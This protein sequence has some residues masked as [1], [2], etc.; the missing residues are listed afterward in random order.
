MADGYGTCCLCGQEKVRIIVHGKSD[1]LRRGCVIQVAKSL[2][3][4][5][6]SD[7]LS[8]REISGEDVVPGGGLSLIIKIPY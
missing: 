3:A 1:Y 2:P 4:M 5:V 7:L 6:R 8:A